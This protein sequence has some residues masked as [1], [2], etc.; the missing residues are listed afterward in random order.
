MP[1]SFPKGTISP[2]PQVVIPQLEDYID[3]GALA[4][5]RRLL[6]ELAARS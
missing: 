4:G 1:V 3:V 2:D 5:E 6:G